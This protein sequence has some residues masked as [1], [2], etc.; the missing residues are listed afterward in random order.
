MDFI[1]SNTQ[2][3]KFHKMN[4]L[5][6]VITTILTF[7]SSSLFSQL[8]TTAQLQGVTVYTAGAE[9]NHTAKANIPAG[10]S[11]VV[12]KNLSGLPDENSIQ[13]GSNTDITIMS[14]SFVKEFLTPESHT[15]Q[16]EKIKDSLAVSVAIL[17]Q[18]RVQINTIKNAQSI[19]EVNK[20]VRGEQ[21]GLQVTELQKMMTYFLE[22]SRELSATLLDLQTKEAKQNERVAMLQRE[23]NELVAGR[24]TGKGELHLQ[25][26][27]GTAQ[28]TT[29]SISYV[30]YSAAWTPMYDLKAKDTKSPLKIIYKANIVQNTGLNWEKVKLSI[31]TNNPNQN[32]TI[33]VLSSWFL[34]YYVPNYGYDQSRMKQP[35]AYMNTVQAFAPKEKN[36]LAKSVNDFT[37]T[38][39]NALS[40][41]FDI[42]LEYDIPSDNKAHSV[43]VKDYEVSANYKYYSVPKLDRDAF[44]VA[45][46]ADW[47]SLNLLPGEAN[48]IFDGTYVGKSYIDPN[49]TQ[50]T[51]NIGMGRDKKIVVKREKVQDFCSSK[52]IGANRVHTV[53]YEIRVKNTRRETIQLLLKDQLPLS[54]Q[55]DMEITALE[56]SDASRNEENGVLTWKLEIPSNETRKVRIQYSV[57]F[58]KDKTIGNLN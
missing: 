3:G 24:A 37:S 12:I 26:L 41:S 38:N 58:P 42:D 4:K 52:M 21:T 15:P 44:L 40:V 53:T 48:I 17:E 16:Q 9:L 22:K 20:V 43:S 33:P 11:E 54:T 49:S 23:Y 10:S 29:F 56:I 50:D 19:L 35:S 46:V 18:L 34:N 32:G 57:K 39:E 51:L 30:S 2:G 8:A 7:F 47:E 14:I 45:E 27:S 6:L 1:S 5:F 28:N 13:V 25:V 31:S 36:D 55:K